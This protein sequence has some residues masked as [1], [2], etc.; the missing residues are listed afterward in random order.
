MDLGERRRRARAAERLGVVRLA[1]P[2]LRILAA[3]EEDPHAAARFVEHALASCQVYDALDWA[4]DLTD[5]QDPRAQAGLRA[6]LQAG[7]LALV[8]RLLPDAPTLEAPPRV[9]APAQWS[10][11]WLAAPR[12]PGAVRLRVGWERAGYRARAETWEAHLRSTPEGAVWIDLL[13]V[14]RRPDTVSA[15]ALAQVVAV[16]KGHP[17]EPVVLAVA[18]H[19]RE[20]SAA[21]VAGRLTGTTSDQLL[22]A[23]ALSEIEGREPTPPAV[24]VA[25]AEGSMAREIEGKVGLSAPAFELWAGRRDEGRIARALYTGDL[26]A[27]RRTADRW[28]TRSPKD[29]RAWLATARAEPSRARTSLDQALELEPCLVEAMVLRARLEDDAERRGWLEQALRASPLDPAILTEARQAGVK[30]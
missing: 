20:L 18:W 16:A 4:R 14:D 8:E 7:D 29:A 24:S 12:V 22:F 1:L 30:P 9:D 6:A 23:K 26:A 11:G 10:E 3:A 13:Q 2:D 15:G 5:P 21:Y 19:R 17:A 27:A 28:T 25:R